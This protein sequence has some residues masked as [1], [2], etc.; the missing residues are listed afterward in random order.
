MIWIYSIKYSGWIPRIE[1]G[2]I[3]PQIIVLP[4]NHIQRRVKLNKKIEY[5]LIKRWTC[6]SFYYWDIPILIRI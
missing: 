5:H 3:T 2:L 4:L 6:S 1:P